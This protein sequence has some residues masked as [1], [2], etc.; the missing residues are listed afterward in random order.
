MHQ[1][2]GPGRRERNARWCG[3]CKQTSQPNNKA[4]LFLIFFYLT[5]GNERPI[6][7]SA[8]NPVFR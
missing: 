4:V 8:L 2:V 7:A 6:T 1:K 5:A 3:E